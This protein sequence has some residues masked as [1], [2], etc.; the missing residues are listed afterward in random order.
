MQGSKIC[1]VGQFNYGQDY[2]ALLSAEVS[3]MTSEDDVSVGYLCLFPK[4][5]GE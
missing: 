5:N 3:I 2:G 1:H 4:Q